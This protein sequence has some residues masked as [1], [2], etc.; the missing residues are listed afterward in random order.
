[1]RT[2]GGS[3][4]I[5]YEFRHLSDSKI[6]HLMFEVPVRFTRFTSTDS[7]KIPIHR[8]IEATLHPR[9]PT[10]QSATTTQVAVAGMIC[11]SYGE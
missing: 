5:G 2:L 6:L 8:G 3:G 1:M 4:E 9:E 10:Y 7:F 11:G